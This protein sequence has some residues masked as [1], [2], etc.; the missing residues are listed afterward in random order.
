MTTY[1]FS[2][3]WP[4][5]YASLL[6]E[7]YELIKKLGLEEE[8]KDPVNGRD[9]GNHENWLKFVR[10]LKNGDEAPGILVNLH[11]I[12]VYGWEAHC[13]LRR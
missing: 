12:A 11:H 3:V 8:L 6:T 2:E 1:N 7:G 5:P 10:A 9:L 4:E 13:K